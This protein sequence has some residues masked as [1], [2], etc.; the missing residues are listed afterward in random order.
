MI[1]DHQKLYELITKTELKGDTA[2]DLR[3]FYN[4]INMCLNAMTRLQEDLVP[5]YQFIKMHS[6]FEEYFIPDS[7]QCSY[8][9]NAQTYTSFG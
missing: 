7:D 6:D 8:Y 5:A 9:W 4:H 3:K 1:S 2:L